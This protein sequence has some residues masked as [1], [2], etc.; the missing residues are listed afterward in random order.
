MVL[1]EARRLPDGLIVVRGKDG[2]ERY[3]YEQGDGTTQGI[4]LDDDNLIV[5]RINLPALTAKAKAAGFDSVGGIE[6]W[7]ARLEELAADTESERAL[8]EDMEEVNNRVRRQRDEARAEAQRY[9][10]RA[11][12]A[13]GRVARLLSL[14]ESDRERINRYKVAG[15]VEADR[16]VDAKNAEI[17]RLR[18]RAEKAEAELAEDRKIRGLL[19]LRLVEE[20]DKAGEPYADDDQQLER[21]I[22]CIAR[23]RDECERMSEAFNV[24]LE[25]M[26]FENRVPGDPDV[27]RLA[28]AIVERNDAWH[29]KATHY[30]ATNERI[31]SE[32][33]RLRELV[34]KYRESERSAVCPSCGTPRPSPLFCPTCDP[35]PTPDRPLALGDRVEFGRDTWTVTRVALDLLGNGYTVEGVPA[36][37]VRRIEGSDG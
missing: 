17:A 7:I 35:D 2:A 10:E 6:A 29:Q 30:G 36:D 1:V 18:E 11:E 16:I 32:C 3:V 34:D 27:M 37:R 13:E 9:K 4:P 26:D 14:A 22:D 12:K 8:V 21:A 15:Y 28:R 20:L 5:H 31:R 25:G 33:G 23:L 19:E 24:V